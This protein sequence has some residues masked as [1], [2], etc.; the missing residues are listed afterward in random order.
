MNG[1]SIDGNYRG[2]SPRYANVS[3]AEALGNVEDKSDDLAASREE[4]G[5]DAIAKWRL[6]GTRT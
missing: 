1:F 3:S 6:Q 5:R 4:M 2:E